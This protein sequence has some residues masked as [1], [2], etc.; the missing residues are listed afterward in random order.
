M[1]DP[2]VKNPASCPGHCPSCSQQRGGENPVCT[3]AEASYVGWRLGLAAAVAFVVPVLA[4][5]AV[6][7][8]ASHLA[9]GTWSSVLAALGAV[10]G[11]V[12]G[13]LAAGPVVV[14][15]QSSKELA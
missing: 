4:A 14:R 15:L 9:G 2:V 12:V 3:Q 7:V 11:L 1:S 8:A 10:F 13:A 6:A 5:I